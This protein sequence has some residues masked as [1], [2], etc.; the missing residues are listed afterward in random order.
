MAESC[1]PP[2]EQS[3]IDPSNCLTPNTLTYGDISGSKMKMCVYCQV[4]GG[5]VSNNCIYPG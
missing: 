4:V 2:L 5:Q 3:L 1:H